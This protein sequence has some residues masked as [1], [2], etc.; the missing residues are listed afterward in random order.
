[1][2]RLKQYVIMTA[3]LVLI[4]SAMSLLIPV[5]GISGPPAKH[6]KV[7]NKPVVKAKQLGSWD[8]KVNNDS[9]EPISIRDEDN[10]ARQP[11]HVSKDVAGG[12]SGSIAERLFTVPP[13]KR[14]VIE[15]ISVSTRNSGAGMSN[16]AIVTTLN[17]NVAPTL[18]PSQ[19]RLF[20][21]SGPNPARAQN[22]GQLVKAY[23]DPVTD[24]VGLISCEGPI[25]Q[26]SYNFN[27]TG[28]LV[29]L[30]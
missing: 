2:G 22:Y 24:I 13:G 5:Y 17:G 11:F 14:A 23:A 9:N 21:N 27:L 18:L 3:A 29:D 12:C 4:V 1:M 30:S 7:V 20:I 28:H 25:V 19:P 26:D 10:P 8:V 15:Y 16:F 6:V